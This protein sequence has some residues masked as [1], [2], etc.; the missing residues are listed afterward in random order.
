M[1]VEDPGVELE[2]RRRRGD[3][4][5]F[6]CGEGVGWGRMMM[7][8]RERRSDEEK[9]NEKRKISNLFLLLKK[10]KKN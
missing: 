2:G 6:E 7:V 9:K 5:F 3:L 8:V 10:K 1:A 4:F